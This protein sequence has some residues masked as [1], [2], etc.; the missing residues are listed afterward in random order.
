MLARIFHN[1]LMRHARGARDPRRQDDVEGKWQSRRSEL[2]GIGAGS[3]NMPMPL[4]VFLYAIPYFL[5]W[6]FVTGN[7]SGASFI[8][9]V[10]C[11]FPLGLYLGR[12]WTFAAI[13]KLPMDRIA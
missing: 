8:L 7:L 6:H 3:Q 9:L 5:I 10:A 4:R 1:T 13:N 2:C 12:L 11:S